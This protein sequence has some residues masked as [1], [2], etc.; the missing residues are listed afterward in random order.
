MSAEYSK[1]EKVAILL[2]NLGAEAAGD[3]LTSFSEEEIAEI[4]DIIAKIRSVDEKTSSKILQE[5]VDQH[6]SLRQSEEIIGVIKDYKPSIVPFRYFR[7]LTNDEVTSIL[8]G[9]HPQLIA[10]VLSYLD[11]DQSAGIISILSEEMRGDVVH[12]MAMASPSPV[13]VIKQID[14]LLEAK[15]VSL[16]D[17]LDTPTERRYRTVA[18]I[19]NRTDSTT[20]KAI[21]QRIREQND[22]VAH[23]IKQL[24]FVF[25]DLASVEDVALRKALSE[26]NSSVIAMSMKTASKAVADKL[27]KNMSK[28]MG[29]MVTEEQELLGPKPLSDVE[30]A[31]K[32][33]VDVLSKMEAQ[34]EK[35]R[36]DSQSAEELV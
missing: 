4:T 25:E 23:E 11:P 6:E 30:A 26:I 1:K 10:L 35:I 21:M 32:E 28:R 22:N 9:E 18:E 33:I 7:N 31:Q 16:G 17:R 3:I 36:G 2:L 14:Q 13:D 27:F 15:V 12:R 19:L 34:G 24:M 29:N 20:E 5:F 8:F